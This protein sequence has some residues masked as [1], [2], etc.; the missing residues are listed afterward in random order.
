MK[1]LTYYLY[2]IYIYSLA[3]ENGAKCSMQMSGCTAYELDGSN[4]SHPDEQ[5]VTITPAET[6]VQNEEELPYI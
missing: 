1:V 5:Y 4:T 3:F 2:I 6:P